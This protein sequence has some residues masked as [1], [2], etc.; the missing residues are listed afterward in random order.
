MTKIS[1]VSGEPIAGPGSSLQVGEMPPR[2]CGRVASSAA[3]SMSL[4]TATCLGS[5]S[6]I[7]LRSTPLT[8]SATVAL[9]FVRV[10]RPRF[11]N[12]LQTAQPTLD[13][14]TQYTSEIPVSWACNRRPK[15][16]LEFADV[17]VHPELHRGLADAQ[18][19][20]RVTLS[21]KLDFVTHSSRIPVTQQ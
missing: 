6:G 16:H 7:T 14:V 12:G 18:V 19:W 4:A 5:G 8:A 21:Q 17:R 13:L 3:A 11:S 9:A 2:L 15:V 1:S 10:L 20:S